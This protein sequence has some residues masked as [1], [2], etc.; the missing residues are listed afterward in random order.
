MNMKKGKSPIRTFSRIIHVVVEGDEEC[1]VDTQLDEA[2]ASSSGTAKEKKPI[3]RASP[4]KPPS[5]KHAPK[6]RG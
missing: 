5:K 1:F 2:E 4:R 6:K 3:G